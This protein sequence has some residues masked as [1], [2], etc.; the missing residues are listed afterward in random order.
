MRARWSAFLLFILETSIMSLAYA[1]CLNGHLSVK[2][3]YDGSRY[4]VIGTTVS[5][6]LAAE[7]SDGYFLD[8]TEYLVRVSKSLKGAAPHVLSVFSENSTGRFPLAI[9]QS[10]LLFLRLVNGRMVVDNC[11]NSGLLEKSGST[12][13][14]MTQIVEHK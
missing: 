5:E 13:S 12:M 1:I 8:G 14:A 3:E 2:L 9:G 10:Y 11:G 7:S 4:I 6:K